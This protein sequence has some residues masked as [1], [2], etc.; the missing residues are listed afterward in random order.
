[1]CHET[2]SFIF[3]EGGIVSA[4]TE[5]CNAKKNGLSGLSG[6]SCFSGCAGEPNKPDEPEKPDKRG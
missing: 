6:L 5:R 4:L 3:S 1:V 2:V